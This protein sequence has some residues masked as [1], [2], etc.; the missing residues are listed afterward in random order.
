MISLELKPYTFKHVALQ[1][2]S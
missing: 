2:L 1:Y